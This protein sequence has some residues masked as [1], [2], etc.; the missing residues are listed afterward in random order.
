MEEGKVF[1]IE[2]KIG[3][4]CIH[5]SLLLFD[6]CTSVFLLHVYDY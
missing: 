6:H 3:V 5:G 4:R 2:S 1:Q